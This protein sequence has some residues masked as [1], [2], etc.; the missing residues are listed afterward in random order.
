VLDVLPDGLAAITLDGVTGPRTARSLR[1]ALP[2]LVVFA[3]LVGLAFDNGGFFPGAW[4]AGAVVLLWATA[5]ALV[6][7]LSLELTALERA[8]LGLQTGLLG[9]TAL[10]LTWSF[11]HPESLLEVRR[12]LVYLAGVGAVLLL[13]SRRSVAHLLGAVWAA[14][15]LVVAYAL[16][17]YLLGPKLY[18]DEFQAN[19]L[20]RP[21]G[22]ANALGIFTGLAAILSV[23][24]AVRAPSRVLRALAA[25]S[26][27]PLAAAVYLTSSRASALA[28]VVGLITM[29]AL[30]RR[31]LELAGALIVL[32]PVAAAVVALSAR[33]RLT[34]PTSVGAAAERQG[35]LLALFIVLGAGVLA[36]GR[37]VVE[38]AARW[39]VLLA[40][41]WRFPAEP[42]LAAAAIL[43]AAAVAVA[44]GRGGFF[45]TGYR[46]TYWHVAWREY[47]AHPWLGSGA[48]TFGD[49]WV[50]YGEPA[51]QGGALDAHNLYLETLAELGPFGLALLASTLALPLVAAFR[52]RAHPFAS[53]ATGAY[54]AFLSHAALD[55]DW[56]M[57]AV[58]L[59]ALVC[60]SAV[61]I[62]GRDGARARVLS[63]H[64]RA[65][66]LAL[67][68]GLALFALA[69]QFVPG[70]KGTLP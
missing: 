17:R 55:W 22:Y 49:Y 58:T 12:G 29:L 48:G 52:V 38:Q 59:A 6:L 68:L 1:D 8:W 63:A 37:P 14:A 69:G 41:R 18:S 46:P 23:A 25:A 56:E 9:W 66:A 13:A 35:R 54:A 62:A 47:E 60:A 2:A 34:D 28:V 26:V 32:A 15:M 51:L 70:L 42:T 16:V 64:A 10:S 24:F 44:A 27:A 21:L 39:S 11:N 5:L 57:P 33:S 30:D 67:T 36:A 3:V 40:R 4:T 19:F 50:R 53:A 61:I 65:G 7:G 20:F 43:G 31:R 45:T